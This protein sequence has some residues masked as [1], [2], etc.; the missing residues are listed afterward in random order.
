MLRFSSRT[1]R[2]PTTSAD[3]TV[4]ARLSLISQYVDAKSV[5]QVV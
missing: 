2:L 4:H 5:L 3:V 1:I